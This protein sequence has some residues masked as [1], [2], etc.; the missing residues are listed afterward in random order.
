[1][2]HKPTCR[3]NTNEH[4]INKSK[5]YFLKEW[6][7]KKP[8]WPLDNLLMPEVNKHPRQNTEEAFLLWRRTAWGGLMTVYTCVNPKAS[9]VAICPASGFTPLSSHRFP[10]YQR[11][12]EASLSLAPIFWSTSQASSSF[13]AK[14]SVTMLAFL[15]SGQP[16]VTQ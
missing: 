12:E 8:V 6:L 9:L 4:E 15:Y 3:Q 16:A 13:L 14:T 2:G 1:M 10:C 5:K 7:W 11:V